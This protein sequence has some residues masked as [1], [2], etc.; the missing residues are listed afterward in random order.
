MGRIHQAT[1]GQ[2]I[3]RI[4]YDAE[5]LVDRPFRELLSFLPEDAE[6]TAY[7]HRVHA[8]L[9]QQL[10][11]LST[12]TFKMGVVHMDI[13]FDNF[14]ITTEGK[15][16]LF[17]FDFCGN[18]WQCIDVAYYMMQ[19]FVTEPI[20]TEYLSKLDA[21]FAGY[22]AV[23]QLSNEEKGILPTLGIALY[24]FYLGIQC[25]RFETFS[26]IFLNEAYLKRYIIVRIKKYADYYK[27]PVG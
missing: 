13:W 3:E 21:F 19:L 1:A 10:P 11:S 5:T 27:L 17:D 25:Q 7:M 18:G 6:E 22:T 8:Y 23:C 20:E 16:T 12:A 2:H 4:Q 14:N 24:V 9:N 26:S 15:I